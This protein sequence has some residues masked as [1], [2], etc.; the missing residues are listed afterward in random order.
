[1]KWITSEHFRFACVTIATAVCLL[2]L[3]VILPT[4]GHHDDD[5]DK[6]MPE[7]QRHG[8]KQMQLFW[9]HV[10]TVV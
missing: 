1:M 6:L 2:K 7:S 10:H 9:I 3:M 4:D 5:G 8:A